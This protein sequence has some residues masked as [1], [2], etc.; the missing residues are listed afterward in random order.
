MKF[1]QFRILSRWRF[2]TTCTEWR[3]GGERMWDGRRWQRKRNVAGWLMFSLWEGGAGGEDG[4]ESSPFSI[5]VNHIETEAPSNAWCQRGEN[6][7]GGREGS[8]WPNGVFDRFWFLVFSFWFLWLLLSSI[9][10]PI[11]LCTD[12]WII[13]WNLHKWACM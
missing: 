12:I 4:E 9:E 10:N 3:Q 6:V 2:I 8:V 11:S 7:Q 1:Y 5:D 13:Y